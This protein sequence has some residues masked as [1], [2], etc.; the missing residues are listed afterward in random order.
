[1]LRLDSTIFWLQMSYNNQWNNVRWIVACTLFFFINS[2][3]TIY[4]VRQPSLT[5]LLKSSLFNMVTLKWTVPSPVFPDGVF[6]C[7]AYHAY[8]TAYEFVHA[9]VL[10]RH[11]LTDAE[12][13][14]CA[15]IP[16]SVVKRYACRITYLNE[17]FM[18][19]KLMWHWCEAQ[20]HHK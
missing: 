5:H 15:I 6:I 14:C 3:L 4:G 20:A 12:C 18:V 1:M 19:F 8:C 10:D 2:C 11:W 16:A 13:L 7:Y 17:Y 9:F